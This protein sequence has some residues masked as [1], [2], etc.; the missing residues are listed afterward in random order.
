MYESKIKN[1]LKNKFHFTDKEIEII[2]NNKI[3]IKDIVAYIERE[4]YAYKMIWTKE[5]VLAS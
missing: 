5:C 2:F 1:V 3:T 4:Y